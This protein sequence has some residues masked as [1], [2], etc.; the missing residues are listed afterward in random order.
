[1]NTDL[2]REQMTNNKR[3]LK[4]QNPETYPM[5]RVLREQCSVALITESKH[6]PHYNT[7]AFGITSLLLGVGSS[8]NLSM[9]NA[10]T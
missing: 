3:L 1:M 10:N 6:A 4:K 9:N 5:D 2:G 8:V 7:T